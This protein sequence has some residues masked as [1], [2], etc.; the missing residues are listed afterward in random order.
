MSFGLALIS[1][2]PARAKPAA[3]IF[4]M[5]HAS[6]RYPFWTD[7]CGFALGADYY[8]PN[9]VPVVFQPLG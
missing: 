4:S 9:A 1:D 2:F 7:S 3:S 5:T 8:F 6:G